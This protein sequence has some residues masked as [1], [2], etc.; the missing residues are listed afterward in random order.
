MRGEE[1]L[2]TGASV[3]ICMGSGRVF[4]R[5]EVVATEMAESLGRVVIASV[6]GGATLAL[7]LGKGI[8][9]GRSRLEK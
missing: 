5:V 6:S 9:L 1:D 8:L 2:G 3:V 4:V 7:M